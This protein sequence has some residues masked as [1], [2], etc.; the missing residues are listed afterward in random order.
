M[1][2]WLFCTRTDDAQYWLLCFFW[3]VTLQNPFFVFL[4]DWWHSLLFFFATWHFAIY[5]IAIV[6][7]RGCGGQAYYQNTGSVFGVPTKTWSFMFFFENTSWS[8]LLNHWFIKRVLGFSVHKWIC[9]CTVVDA[10]LEQHSGVMV[11]KLNGGSIFTVT[12]WTCTAHR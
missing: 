10:V 12:R 8:F 4:N 9:F 1:I 7:N 6:Y 2:I 3:H 11:E 5:H